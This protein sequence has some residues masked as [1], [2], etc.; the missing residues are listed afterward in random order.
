[1]GVSNIPFTSTRTYDLW[2][3]ASLVI[4]YKQL[5]VPNFMLCPVY[6]SVNKH[7]RLKHE[8]LRRALTFAAG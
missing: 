5:L 8:E 6:Q 4:T 3:S 2:G 1:M 7:Y